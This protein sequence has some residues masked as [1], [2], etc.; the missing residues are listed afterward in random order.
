MLVEYFD[1]FTLHLWLNL[2]PYTYP[3]GVVIPSVQN[4]EQNKKAE[5]SI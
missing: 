3:L 4:A 5:H 1:A 2:Q